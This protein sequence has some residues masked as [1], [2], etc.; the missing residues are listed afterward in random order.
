MRVLRIFLLAV[1]GVFIVA[2]LAWAF[3]PGA[4]LKDTPHDF[5]A[6][7]GG[8][9]VCT[10][11]HTPHRALQT[12]LLWNHTLPTGYN[13]TWKDIDKTI[14][15]TTLPTILSGPG[16]WSGPTKLCLS[17][18]DGSVA[19]GDINWWNEG[20]PPAP[21]DN[22]KHAWPDTYN[23]GATDGDLG[24]MKGNHPVAVPYP[25][26][27]AKNTYGGTTT[28]DGVLI[29]EFVAN[30]AVN[31]IRLFNT[32]G[33]SSV[34][35]GAVAGSTGIECSSCH[36]PHNGSTVEDDL[37]LRGKLAGNALP[38]ICLKCHNK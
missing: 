16:G 36:D 35:A 23:V 33:G 25:Y 37:F 29:A 7:G 5:S 6:K 10:F 24:N 9:G 11:C 32:S 22:T 18:H 17:C 14:G 28:G 1:V 20:K 31:N 8:V 26:A 19:V 27:N 12:R 30:P 34:Q 3:T 15:G 4:G 13:Y 2:G 21:L 38:Y